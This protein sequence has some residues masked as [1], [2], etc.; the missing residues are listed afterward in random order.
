MEGGKVREI[1]RT[2]S[3]GR[4]VREVIEGQRRDVPFG[5]FYR[6]GRCLWG[7]PRMEDDM[8][9]MLTCLG[10][11]KTEAVEHYFYEDGSRGFRVILGKYEAPRV[12]RGLIT[13]ISEYEDGDRTV[14]GI[15]PG[16]IEFYFFQ[17]EQE[18]DSLSLTCW[19]SGVSRPGHRREFR[20]RDR[21]AA[22]SHYRKMHGRTAERIR[23]EGLPA[24]DVREVTRI[25]NPRIGVDVMTRG[26]RV[27]WSREELCS[28]YKDLISLLGDVPA[29][30]YSYGKRPES[31]SAKSRIRI[32]VPEGVEPKPLDHPVVTQL[33]DNENEAVSLFPSGLEAR[34]ICDTEDNK[35]TGQVVKCNG[36]TL[37]L[38][39]PMIID[40]KSLVRERVFQVPR[41]RWQAVNERYCQ[42]SLSCWIFES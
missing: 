34:V 33:T 39:K 38:R 7:R 14:S 8:D 11:A 28:G 26:G 17:R 42:N 36:I 22:L 29:E 31:R 35:L 1:K 2:V 13:C 23:E 24:L 30:E 21:E 10:D 25:F 18:E 9:I 19:F 16:G 4:T 20:I 37:K 6:Y 40:G 15:T 5:I 3:E 12:L 41:D 32:C 27:L